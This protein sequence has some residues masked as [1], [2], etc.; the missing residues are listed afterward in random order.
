MQ[1]T[2][3]LALIIAMVL[4]THNSDARV[5]SKLPLNDDLYFFTDIKD[6]D[7]ETG[8]S[9]DDSSGKRDDDSSGK[10]DDDS[11]G[12]SDD[13]DSS[14]KSDDD[15]SSGKSDDDDDSSNK[16]GKPGDG[17]DDCAS[18]GASPC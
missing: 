3:T 17:N 9:D 15:D 6:D 4:L 11:S 2:L 10:S 14:G 5:V 7:G 16:P 8:E 12:K 1:K 18:S 13:D